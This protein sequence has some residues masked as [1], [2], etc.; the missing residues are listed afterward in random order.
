[1]C[2]SRVF[3]KQPN[4]KA[5]RRGQHYPK[6]LTEPKSRHAPLA[7]RPLQCVVSRTAL[8]LLHRFLENAGIVIRIDLFELAIHDTE[9]VKDGGDTVRQA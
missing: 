4:A 5:Q 9:L 6:P 3:L 2:L 8:Q 1:M 7:P